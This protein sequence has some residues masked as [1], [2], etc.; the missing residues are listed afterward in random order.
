M[1][2]TSIIPHI[3]N[4]AIFITLE[5]A[6]LSMLFNNG[7]LQKIWISKGAHAVMG[8]LW[9]WT[10]GISDYFSLKETNDA[11]AAENHSL[12]VKLQQLEEILAER[13]EA[14]VIHGNS[15]KRFRFINASIIK[16]SSNLQHNY[17]IIDKG[18]ADGV[19]EGAG[20]ITGKGAIGVIDAVSRN[21]S[22]AI[23]FQNYNMSISSRIGRDGRHGP[24]VWDGKG[25]NSAVLKEI[26]HHLEIVP[27]DTVYTS[28]YSSIFPADI[29]LGTIR[30]AEIVNGA[31]YDIDI[32]L[33]EDFGALRYVTVVENIAQEQLDKLE[34]K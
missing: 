23:S 8:G 7:T 5:I 15:T 9:G 32:T 4:A 19:V 25:S 21:Y 27:G 14:P 3:I 13:G 26:P 29:P 18:A 6:A 30:K 2:K 1:R 24:L 10:Q 16:I 28:G 17:F 31:T 33:F 12:M 11:L 34:D 22:Y 20:V